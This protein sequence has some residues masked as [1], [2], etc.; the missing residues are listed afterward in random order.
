MQINKSADKLETLS[1]NFDGEALDKL[2]SKLTS[3]EQQ[4]L[5]NGLQS[6]QFCATNFPTRPILIL[7]QK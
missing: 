2:A 1:A 7:R 4:H 5:E 3:H 6:G